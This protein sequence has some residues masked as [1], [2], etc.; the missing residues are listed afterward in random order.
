MSSVLRLETIQERVSNGEILVIVKNKVYNLT[1]WAPY[2][3]GGELILKHLSGN[4]FNLGKD[5]T[6]A[7]IAFHPA[8][9]WNQKMPLFCIGDLD[10][11]DHE[12]NPI[13]QS[14]RKLEEQLHALNL[15]ETDYWFF[16]RELIKFGLLWL[17]MLYFGIYGTSFGSYFLS[18]SCAGLLWHQAA[19]FAHDGTV[20]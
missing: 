13:S 18:A 10:P 20:N 9:V 2:H 7:T 6:D 12:T 15:F 17:S 14:Y 19:F 8:W 11:R 1:K 3:P 4:S 5:A 16:I